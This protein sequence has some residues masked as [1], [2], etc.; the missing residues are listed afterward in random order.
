MY[1]V[2]LKYLAGVT[3][4]SLVYVAAARFSLW[5]VPGVQNSVA[6]VWLP[7]G[8]ALAAILVFG[9]RFWP[10]I[11]IGAL[12]MTAFSGFPAKTALG[13]GVGNTLEA[14]LATYLLHRIGAF[15]RALDRLWDVL[16]FVAMASVCAAILGATF[17]VTSLGWGQAVDRSTAVPTWWTWW[18]GDALGMLLVTPLLLTWSRKWRDDWALAQVMEAAGLLTLL[19]VF[20]MLFFRDWVLPPLS[21]PPEYLFFPFVAWAALR[22]G[23]R[24]SALTVFAATAITIWDWGN[25]FGPAA[26]RDDLESLLELLSFL[27]VLS[28]T[29]MTLA[30]VTSEQRGAE[31]ALRRRTTELAELNL[32]LSS[33][34]VQRKR[35][36]RLARGQTE[37]L[38]KSLLFLSAEPDL[39]TFWGHALK[40]IVEELEGTGGA[41]WFPD[42]DARVLR[43][44]LECV[45]G[46]IRT[47]AESV[48]PAAR[49]SILFAESPMSLDHD[50][51][52]RAR[53]YSEGNPAIPP[54]MSKYLRAIGAKSLLSVSM[55]VGERAIAWMTVR[56]DETR[57][58]DP[59]STLGFAEAL[60]QQATLA[61]EMARLSGQARESAVLAER[62]RIARDI[63]D[64]L[65]QG[66]TG[67][68]LQLQAA[69]DALVSGEAAPVK[70]HISRASE[71]ARSALAEARRSVRA[72]R[73]RVLEAQALPAA[74]D[75]MVRKMTRDTRIE[76]KVSA[77]GQPRAL[78]EECEDE[79]IRIVQESLTNTIKH[80]NASR[81]EVKLLFE[82]H[83]TQLYILD[84]GKG[85]DPTL[86]YD[87]FG[88]IGMR[89]R[90]SRIGGE[91][92]ITS[93]PGKGSEIRVALG[94]ARD[95]AL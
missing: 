59:D 28:V 41:L 20:S 70:T 30:A 67:V 52:S 23:P 61:I 18:L 43:L 80:A 50:E 82:P 42:Y 86:P 31:M 7:S 38:A 95:D 73:P 53:F 37:A 10:G 55:V 79:I 45:D 76:P 83:R 88:L 3:A 54:A 11:L 71:L 17:G 16:G 84:D 47:A 75:A 13:I 91:L 26:A 21:Y 6:P 4:F 69:E 85:F 9:Y 87:G 34:I 48:H 49:Q 90:A 74:L 5:L 32:A 35:A 40:A 46:R 12:A 14:M 64:T 60:G 24:G 72:V 15:H 2:T 36:E 93:S 62:N 66:F 65:A 92:S 68:I 29:G 77:A 44:H 51:G 63:H 78:A 1:K 33:E 58:A 94:S 81:F 25:G 39:E 19:I 89:E 57:L 56:G 8:I 27:A 22:L